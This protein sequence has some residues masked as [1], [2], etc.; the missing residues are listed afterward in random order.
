[1][2]NSMKCKKTLRKVAIILS[3]I[4]L[5]LNICL[6]VKMKFTWDAIPSASNQ[7]DSMN[8]LFQGIFSWA[9][10]VYGI[11]LIPV[12][13]IEYLLLVLVI[14]IYHKFDGII[15]ACLCLLISII[16]ILIF[17]FFVRMLIFI[18]LTLI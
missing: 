8:L 13:W 7:H 14:K 16:F 3:I 10:L 18:I 5:L 15:G 4:L 17:I 1:M 2:Q 9:V 6:Y 11:I 12:V